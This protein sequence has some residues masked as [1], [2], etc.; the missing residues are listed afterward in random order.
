MIVMKKVSFSLLDAFNAAALVYALGL[1]AMVGFRSSNYMAL[2]VQ[3]VASIDIVMLYIWATSQQLATHRI[4]AGVLGLTSLL[5]ASSIIGLE[6]QER[7]NFWKRIQR[8]QIGQDSW[9]KTLDQMKKISRTARENGEEINIIY[10]KSLFRNRDHLK[11]QLAYNR[12]IYFNL[13]K[14]KYT[15]IDGTGKGSEYI[16]KKGDFLL[17]IDTG[18]R[19]FDDGLNDSQYQKIYDYDP[20]TSNGK[21][22]RRVQ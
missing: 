11:Q 6:H 4:K 9:V 14:N 12:L 22:Y 8:I 2:P 15:V 16:P 3:F 21:I 18:K 10:S 13:E 5:M 7:R 19:L 20:K 17:N 1:C